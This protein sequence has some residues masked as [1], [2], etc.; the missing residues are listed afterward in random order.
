MLR[1]GNRRL[2]CLPQ[3]MALPDRDKADQEGKDAE[4]TSRDKI[5]GG[6]R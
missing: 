1:W 4:E 3:L 2:P 6:G 5:G